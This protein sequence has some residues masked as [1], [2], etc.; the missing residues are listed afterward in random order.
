MCENTAQLKENRESTAINC[1]NSNCENIDCWWVIEIYAY[2]IG[3]ES[4]TQQALEF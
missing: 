3:V 1:Y 4:K 2:K